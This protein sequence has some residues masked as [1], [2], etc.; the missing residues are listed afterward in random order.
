M[1]KQTGYLQTEGQIGEFRTYFRHLEQM[2]CPHTYIDF[3]GFIRRGD[4]R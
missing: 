2:I 1:F 4:S 3:Y